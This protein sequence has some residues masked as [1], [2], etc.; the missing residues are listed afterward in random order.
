MPLHGQLIIHNDFT[1]ESRNRSPLA[2]APVKEHRGTNTAVLLGG[3][4]PIKVPVKEHRGT[5]TA[6]Q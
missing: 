1:G 3:P 5:N 2:R 6:V 4:L